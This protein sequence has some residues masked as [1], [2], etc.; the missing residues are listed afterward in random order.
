MRMRANVERPCA[1]ICN[2]HLELRIL[3][4][5]E[6]ALC[7]KRRAQPRSIDEDFLSWQRGC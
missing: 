3:A 2:P 6:G 5:V 7:E 4:D 1:A